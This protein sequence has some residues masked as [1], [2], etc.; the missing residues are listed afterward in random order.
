MS[1][2]GGAPREVVADVSSNILGSTAPAW[3]GYYGV[4]AWHD[5]MAW[6]RGAPATTATVVDTP[7]AP[8]SAVAAFGEDGS[9]ITLLNPDAG[10]TLG[11][12]TVGYRPSVVVRSSADQVLI[13]QA[14][15]PGPMS[16]RRRSRSSP[17]TTS[18][19]RS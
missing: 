12:V 14:F 17:C 8:R 16:R 9:E 13:S 7:L 15:G 1:S 4:V 10:F 11:H 3:F 2:S 6:W 5:V 19:H 18:P